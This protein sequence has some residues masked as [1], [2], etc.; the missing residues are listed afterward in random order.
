M[1]SDLCAFLLTRLQGD[2]AFFSNGKLKK[3]L[4]ARNLNLHFLDSLK[5]IRLAILGSFDKFIS[6]N[7]DRRP[8]KQFLL[9]RAIDPGTYMNPKTKR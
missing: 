2:A 6:L 1:S 9:Q 8:K 7:E 3:Y 5:R 4:K